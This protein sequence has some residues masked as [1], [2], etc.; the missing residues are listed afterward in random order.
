[1]LCLWGFILKLRETGILKVELKPWG[2]TQWDP[3][4][5]APGRKHGVEPWPG[6][7]M[8]NLLYTLGWYDISI[9]TIDAHSTNFSILL[10][11]QRKFL[12]LCIMKNLYWTRCCTFVW[13][14]YLNE[15]K[16]G[17]FTWNQ[18]STI[19]DSNNSMVAVLGH[20]SLVSC[21]FMFI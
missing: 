21:G 2:G 19:I 15:L 17:Y 10:F 9:Y 8:W 14:C 18:W 16:F 12:S 5:G 7:L 6:T 4:G 20:K 13:Q 1:M 3:K 11:L